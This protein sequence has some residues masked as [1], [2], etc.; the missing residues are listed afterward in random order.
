MGPDKFTR[1]EVDRAFRKFSDTVK[2]VFDAKFQTWGDAFTHMMTHCEQNPVMQVVTEPLRQNRN[3]DG[4]KW[5]LDAIASVR[6]M[7]GSGHYSLPIDDD[8]RTALLYQA[9][10]ALENGRVDFAQFCMSVYG[11]THYQESVN[12]FNRELVAKFVREVGYRLEEIEKDLGDATE[13]MREAMQVFHYHDHSMNVQGGIHGSNIAVGSS[14]VTNSTATVETSAD[15]A[16]SLK[17]LKPLLHE[18][19]EGHR[20]AVEAAIERLIESA[21]GKSVPPAELEAAAETVAKATPSFRERLLGLAGKLGTSL[22]G[23]AI[24]QAIK[25]AVGVH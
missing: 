8:D 2:D 14:T 18:V 6:G 9:F 21:E 19:A 11:T 22:T 20:I 24:F 17:A 1:R 3:V 5:W 7:V 16:A 13:V 25:S 4:E 23:S 12:T 10:L 15:L